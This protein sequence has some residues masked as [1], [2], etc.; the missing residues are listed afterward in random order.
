MKI[1]GINIKTKLKRK[2]T[3]LR[4]RWENSAYSTRIINY[5]QPLKERLNSLLRIISGNKK[6]EAHKIL[7]P[8]V[9]TSNNRSFHIRSQ[10][11]NLNQSLAPN[12]RLINSNDSRLLCIKA[13]DKDNRER[14]AALFCILLPGSGDF[15][16]DFELCF[17]NIL[18]K[19][20]YLCCFIRRFN[21]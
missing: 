15:D 2:A 11:L 17:V 5:S 3:V 21:K 1:I 6:G 7:I 19:G 12:P 13:N 9:N 14:Q 20:K 18:K 4:K 10:E 16:S 8:N